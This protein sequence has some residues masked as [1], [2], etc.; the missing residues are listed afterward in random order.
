MFCAIIPYIY[1]SRSHKYR[2]CAPNVYLYM[3]KSFKIYQKCCMNDFLNLL[4]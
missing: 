1:I 3:K 2:L 4:I